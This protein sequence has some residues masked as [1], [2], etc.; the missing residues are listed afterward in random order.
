MK[1]FDRL[2]S[3]S[4]KHHSPW[5][6]VF[7]IVLGLILI[8][9][10][11]VFIADTSFLLNILNTNFGINSVVLVHVISIV[12]LLCGFLIVA[13]LASRA[14]ALIQIPIVLGAIFLVNLHTGGARI[15]E[16]ILS[17][18]VLLLLVMVFIKG[19]GKFSAYYYLINSKRSRQ[20][21]ESHGD[22]KGGS[23][24]AP[25]DNEANIL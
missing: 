17:L 19:S 11:F 8:F 25:M 14:A 22:Y 15:G 16:L 6:D 18:I 3:W 9:K 12:H 4:E 7:R 24:V 2:E 5:M 1:L 10:G 23:S 13:G 20:T 21:D